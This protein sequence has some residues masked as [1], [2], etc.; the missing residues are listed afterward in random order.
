MTEDHHNHG[1][2]AGS[3]MNFCP[4]FFGLNRFSDLKAAADTL[5]SQSHACTDQQEKVKSLFVD[6]YWDGTDG[7]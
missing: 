3:E 2:W 6:L 7:E 1:H 5:S 4:N